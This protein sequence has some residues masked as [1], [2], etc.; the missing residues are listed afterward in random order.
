LAAGATY[1]AAFTT[2]ANGIFVHLRPT[3][4]SSTANSLQLRIAE[5]SIVTGG[6]ALVPRNRNRNSKNISHVSVVGGVTIA[7]EGTILQY[8]QVGG[9]T[10]ASNASGGGNDGSAEEWVLKPGTTYT[11]RFENIGASTATIGYWN[12]FWYEE[13]EGE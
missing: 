1:S 10:N 4:L 8:A 7:T 3:G 12:M 5:N 11:F 9:G 2:P 6:T 13:G